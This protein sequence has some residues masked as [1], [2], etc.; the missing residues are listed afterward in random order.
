MPGVGEVDAATTLPMAAVCVS[1]SPS[2]SPRERYRTPVVRVE[3]VG[4]PFVVLVLKA[5]MVIINVIFKT[6]GRPAGAGAVASVVSAALC[7]VAVVV[8]VLFP[9][10]FR[11]YLQD[12]APG[13]RLRIKQSRQELTGLVSERGTAHK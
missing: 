7:D 12:L 2:P 4:R 1:P 9:G 3:L 11:W 8:A 5:I 10:R 13:N 6:T